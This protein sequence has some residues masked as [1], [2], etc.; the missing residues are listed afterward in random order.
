[1]D[2]LGTQ[3]RRQRRKLA[4]S[5]DDVAKLTGISKPYLSLVETNKTKSPPSDE[6]L[7]RLEETLQFPAGALVVR[8]HLARTPEDVQKMLHRLLTPVGGLSH[9]AASRFGSDNASA[10]T[11]GG[12]IGKTRGTLISS[13]VTTGV[14]SGGTTGVSGGVST[15]VSTSVSSSAGTAAE[16]LGGGIDLD[17]AYLSGAL[18]A[19]A[20]E[21]GGNAMLLGAGGMGHVPLINKVSAGYPKDFTDLDYPARIAD[22]YVPTPATGDPHLFAARVHGLSMH[23]KYADG[24]IVV[25]S[26][27]IDPKSGDDCFVRLD[28]GQTTFKQVHFEQTPEGKHTVRLQPL[29]PAFTPK[30]LAAERVVGVYKAVWVSRA[31]G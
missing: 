4:L 6:K 20:E 21:R 22:E 30:V 17:A 15:G 24:D 8:A 1:M 27:S 12:P 14:S 2:P 5:L 29:N 3:L 25:F 19:L 7:K 11:P 18:Q 16:R 28:S 9:H 13:G 10:V 31:V 26:P 23:P